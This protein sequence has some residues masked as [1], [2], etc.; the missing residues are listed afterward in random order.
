[1][2]FTQRKFTRVTC[3]GCKR[4]ADFFNST[5]DKR[6]FKKELRALGWV[7]GE[8]GDYCPDCKWKKP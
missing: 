3:D 6:V 8:R 4:N 5:F 1:M 2:S 7:F